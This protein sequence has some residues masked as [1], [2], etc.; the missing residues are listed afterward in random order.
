[1]IS[2]LCE[3]LKTWVLSIVEDDPIPLEVKY[4]YF[5][6][7]EDLKGFHIEFGGREKKEKAIYFL[8]YLPLEGEF[9]NFQFDCAFS[10]VPLYLEQAIDSAFLDDEFKDVFKDKEIYIASYGK[11]NSKRLK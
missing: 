5:L 3:T 2:L 8:D 7:H 10:E 11:S 9:L 1:M 6:I 4:M